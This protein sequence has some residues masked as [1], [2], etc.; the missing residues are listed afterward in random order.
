MEVT[1]LTSKKVIMNK[2][3]ALELI[4]ENIVLIQQCFFLP[5]TNHIILWSDF[6]DTYFA[7]LDIGD[8]TITLYCADYTLATNLTCDPLHN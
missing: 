7:V 6:L 4:I 2:V 5:I 8:Y 3:I 1:L